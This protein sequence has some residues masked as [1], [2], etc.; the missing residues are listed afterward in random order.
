M[1]TRLFAASQMAG[2]LYS[3]VGGMPIKAL[4][5][6][7]EFRRI[8]VFL[9]MWSPQ[10]NPE[11]VLVQA[12]AGNMHA[13]GLWVERCCSAGIRPRKHESATRLIVLLPGI[14]WGSTS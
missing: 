14:I 9:H 13:L 10:R 1:A 7:R 2:M 11:L 5:N 4:Q 6:A 8:R 3:C 12:V